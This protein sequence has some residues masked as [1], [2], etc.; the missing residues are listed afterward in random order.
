MESLLTTLLVQC[1]RIQMGIMLK[2]GYY[3]FSSIRYMETFV[4]ANDM[5]ER[6]S[7]ETVLNFSEADK[8]YLSRQL[9][10]IELLLK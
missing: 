8:D 4:V 6:L 10:P 9:L 3:L 7:Q 5:S 2:R 1:R